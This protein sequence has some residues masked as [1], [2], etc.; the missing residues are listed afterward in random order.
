MSWA[1]AELTCLGLHD[2]AGGAGGPHG[3]GQ[4]GVQLNG[5]H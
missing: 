5:F 4:G 2:F 3:G 1:S